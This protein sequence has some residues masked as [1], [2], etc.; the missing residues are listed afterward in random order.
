MGIQWDHMDHTI[1]SL[2]CFGGCMSGG[3]K[4]TEDRYWK[5]WKPGHFKRFFHQIPL[6]NRLGCERW[7]L[8]ILILLPRW[9]LRNNKMQ[10][11]SPKQRLGFPTGFTTRSVP[12]FQHQLKNQLAKRIKKLCCF[13]APRLR[14]GCSWVHHSGI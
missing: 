4:G 2:D 14:F 7:R 9:L 8:P 10:P 5:R 1:F 11:L 13:D 12:K 3:T 6:E